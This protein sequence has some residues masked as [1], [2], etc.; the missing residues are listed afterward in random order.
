MNSLISVIVPC[1][2]QA[3]YL[4]DCL[5]SVL[6]QTYENWECIIV[7]DGSPDNTEE[8]ARKWVDKDA[9][10]KYLLQENKGVSAARNFGILNAQGEWILPLDADDLI[11]NN[12]LE[13]ASEHFHIND[14]QVIYCNAK[15]FGKVD[16]D[17]KL[18]DFSLLNLAVN[19]VIF[20]TAFFRRS[21]CF[22]IGGYDETMQKGYEDWDFWIHMLKNGGEVIK[23]ESICF[24]YRIKQK[25][26][27][28]DVKNNSLAVIK[29]I[30]T[31]HID[32]FHQQFGTMNSLFKQNK[33]YENIVETVIQ[34][35]SLSKFVNQMYSLLENIKAKYE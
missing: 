13:L 17:F 20:C 4:D 25:S 21:T 33:Q 1:Y 15:K 5:Q 10:F 30:E 9:R 22:E 19:N 26:R 34:K 6:D 31:K 14:V 18:E 24:F 7:N 28:V 27:N 35:R 16:E 29:Y 11:S 23:L 2:N 3:Q 12:Y 32:F 8:V